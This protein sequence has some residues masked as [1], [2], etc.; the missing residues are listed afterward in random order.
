MIVQKSLAELLVRVGI[1][2]SLFL[3]IKEEK[4]IAENK[5][6]DSISRLL[7]LKILKNKPK[8]SCK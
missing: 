1:R 8:K 2:R 5:G 7:I 4:D 6:I 3:S